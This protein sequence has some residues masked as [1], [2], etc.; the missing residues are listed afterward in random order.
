[1][2]KLNGTI[3]GIESSGHLSVVDVEVGGDV[4]SAVIIETP[5]TADYL[6]VGG[7]ILLLFKETEVILGKG[8]GGAI[9]LKNRLACTVRG[10]ARQKLLTEISLE[11]RG[12]PI[13]AVLVSACAEGIGLREGDAVDAFIKVNEITLMQVNG[14]GI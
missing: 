1:M 7:D 11:Y 8:I 3:T 12:N 14:H 9:S 2:N 5:E 13:H 10:I 4:L 6:R